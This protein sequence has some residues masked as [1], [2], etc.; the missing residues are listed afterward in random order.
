MTLNAAGSRVASVGSCG[1]AKLNFHA[2]LVISSVFLRPGG[3]R[4]PTARG[5]NKRDQVVSADYRH[6][7]PQMYICRAGTLPVKSSLS[8]PRPEPYSKR[9]RRNIEY[10]RQHSVCIVA[11]SSA[12]F[13]IGDNGVLSRYLSTKSSME[14]NGRFK[15]SR[16]NRVA[17]STPPHLETG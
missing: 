11:Q 10:R 5:V 13:S 4:T 17:S 7:V 16:L 3:I 12:K 6:L 2:K 9:G 1:P 15:K 14:D 8:P